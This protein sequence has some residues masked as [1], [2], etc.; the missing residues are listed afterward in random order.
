MSFS[1]IM[2]LLLP[3]TLETVEMVF[4]SSVFSIIIGL[5]LA[6]LLYTIREDGLNPKKSLYKILDIIVNILR[7]IPFVILMIIVLPLSKVIVGTKIGTAASIVPLTICAIPFVARLFEDEFTGIDK[8]IIEA[9]KSMGSTNSEIIWKVVIPETIPGLISS[10]TNLIIN[11][12]GYSAMSGFIGGGGL[13]NLAIRYGYNRR[14]N[15]VLLA[16]V[17]AIV[18]L[19]QIVQYIG[20]KLSIKTNKK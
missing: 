13:G 4:F 7:S 19:V 3:S 18:I 20:R 10:S 14:E 16:S 2:D 6:I 12:I 9:A 15:L 8:G 5:L 1:E 11:L 17:V